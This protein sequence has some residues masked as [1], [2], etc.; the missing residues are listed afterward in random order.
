MLEVSKE[1]NVTYNFDLKKPRKPRMIDVD[2]YGVF[3][4]IIARLYM[5][6]VGNGLFLGFCKIHKKYFVD[7]KHLKG[8]IRCPIC[9]EKWL[10][11][12]GY[13]KNLK[14]SP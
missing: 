10:M 5:K 11:E 4:R 8:D 7:Y 1:E 3:S 13:I 14:I 6:N 9:D 2:K 12:H